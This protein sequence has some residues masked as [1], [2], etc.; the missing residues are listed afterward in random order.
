MSNR[1]HMDDPHAVLQA[2]LHRDF[3]AF[4]RKAFPAIRGGAQLAWNWHLDAIAHQLEL[5]ARGDIP[6]E[7][8]ICSYETARQALL[9]VVPPAEASLLEEFSPRR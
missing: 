5:V 8:F 1:I 2:L 4:L 7:V 3:R 6:K 9:S